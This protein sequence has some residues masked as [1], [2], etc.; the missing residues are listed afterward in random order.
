MNSNFCEDLTDYYN[1]AINRNDAWE[2]LRE[3]LRNAA[4][5]RFDH[6]IVE[7]F[8]M[9]RARLY[10]KN[11]MITVQCDVEKKGRNGIFWLGAHKRKRKTY[12]ISFF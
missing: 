5:D 2:W 11:Q 12:C 9:E 8:L 6:L 1:C 10:M 7:G 3:E 4:R